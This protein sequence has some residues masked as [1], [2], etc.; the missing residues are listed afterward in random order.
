M[1]IILDLPTTYLLPIYQVNLR[2][3]VGKDFAYSGKLFVLANSLPTVC[4]GREK[5]LP[6]GYA[7]RLRLNEK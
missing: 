4:E 5:E 3:G 6:G 1:K 2:Q 7:Q